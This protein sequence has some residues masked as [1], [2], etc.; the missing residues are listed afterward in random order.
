MYGIWFIAILFAVLSIGMIIFMIYD[1]HN[2]IHYKRNKIACL[3]ALLALMAIVSIVA[4]ATP[5]QAK[6]EYI[7]FVEMKEILEN[8]EFEDFSTD[9]TI[10][11]L[12]E[13]LA[14]AR[15]DKEAKGCF[16]K[17]YYLDLEALEPIC[18]Y[19][20]DDESQPNFPPNTESI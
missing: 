20:E 18:S 13:W 4:I 9:N 15:A 5:I 7:K 10:L 1:K 14:T 8:S 17:Y 12:N 6:K 11:E 16:S 3:V 19:Q 2:L